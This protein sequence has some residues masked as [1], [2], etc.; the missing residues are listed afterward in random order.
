[1]LIFVPAGGHALHL[2]KPRLRLFTEVTKWSSLDQ[3]GGRMEITSKAKPFIC[4][5]PSSSCVPFSL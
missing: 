1:M 2:Q 4:V 3:P 5:D